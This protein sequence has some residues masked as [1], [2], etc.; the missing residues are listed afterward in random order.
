MSKVGQDSSEMESA[1]RG[2]AS[3]QVLWA[4][5][6]KRFC[7]F[8]PVA[9]Y[10][11]SI[12]NPG[13]DRIKRQ[14]VTISRPP[15]PAPPSVSPIVGFVSNYNALRYIQSWGTPPSPHLN[16]MLG[17]QVLSIISRC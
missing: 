11:P 8:A 4:W 6:V 9:P 15:K 17:V 2:L 1:C 13:T 16:G 14:C 12:H 7:R 5:L 10:F 3:L